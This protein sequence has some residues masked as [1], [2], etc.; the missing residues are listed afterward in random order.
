MMRNLIPR[1]K[2]VRLEMRL[3]S[4]SS[5]RLF[6][7]VPKKSTLQ[8]RMMALHQRQIALQRLGR[9]QL[10]VSVTHSDSGTGSPSPTVTP[11]PISPTVTECRSELQAD[12]LEMDDLDQSFTENCS[13]ESYTQSP[14]K[15]PKR[16]YMPM[17]SIGDKVFIARSSAFG[18]FIKQINR[19]SQCKTKGCNGKLMLAGV[20]TVGLGGEI[21]LKFGCSG[22][23]NHPL[24]I[25]SSA[26]L[27][28]LY[29]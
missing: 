20:R 9:A 14:A 16:S 11:S 4:Q 12:T 26:L 15:R 27:A 7:T 8:R 13:D 10:E 28:L 23:E 18:D 6:S 1:L 22:C 29:K 21:L 3:S 24:V 17:K 25:E 2:G 19:T 5:K